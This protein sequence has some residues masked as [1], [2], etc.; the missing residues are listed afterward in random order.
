M[1]KDL[2]RYK[3]LD[4][5]Y[6]VSQIRI[7]AMER[8]QQVQ[9]SVLAEHQSIIEKQDEQLKTKDEQMEIKDQ[10]SDYWKGQWR[11]QKGKTW[12][13]GLIGIAVAILEFFVFI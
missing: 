3:G 4:S 10:Q 6:Q 2:I 8:I 13:V 5:A 11:K 1:V 9:D 12:L 7:K